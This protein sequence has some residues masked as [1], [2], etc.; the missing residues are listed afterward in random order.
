MSAGARLAKVLSSVLGAVAALG[1]LEVVLR[2]L[3]TPAAPPQPEIARDSLD[4]P[5]VAAN[6][7]EEGIGRAHY[8]V[9]GARLTGRAPLTGAPVIVLLGDSY[10]AARE[11]R[12]EETMGAW[13]E[14]N[15]GDAGTPITVRQY[16][17]RGVSPAQYLLVAAD[18]RRRWKPA[19]V[20]IVL[21]RDDLDDHALAGQY[22]RLKVRRD[23]SLIVVRGP[24]SDADVPW[25]LRHSALAGLAARRGE[26]LVSR[27]PSA[28]RE[29]LG[30]AGGGWN[31]PPAAQL[32]VLPSAVVRALATA[33]GT[34]LSILYAADVRVTG[35]EET[36]PLERALLD[37]CARE[38]VTC[39]SSRPAML[40]AQRRG[41]IARGFPT[42]TLGVGH[43][44]PDGHRLMGALVWPLVAADV[45]TKSRV[46]VH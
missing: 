22:P 24:D 13:L 40:E 25:L 34:Q 1:V 23:T 31:A 18:V 16:G 10:V 36:D 7:I 15:A 14:R 26:R 6:Q 17:W 30:V 46:A 33:Y 3:V 28:L 27:G 41:I 12:D 44:N 35:G 5:I 38:R 9:T 11:V 19:H 43:L 2:M 20:V 37:A 32:A 45:E 42:T 29:A 39:V 8:T 21:S 4:A